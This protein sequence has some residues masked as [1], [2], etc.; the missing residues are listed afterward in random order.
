MASP[1]SLLPTAPPPSDDA[2]AGAAHSVREK[3]DEEGK[4]QQAHH[5]HHAALGGGEDE[6]DEEDGGVKLG[7]G[8]F[9]FYSVL[10]GRAAVYDF[11]TT[12][13]C[14]LAITTGLILTLFCLALF[15]KALPALPCSI[16]LGIATYAFTRFAI[17]PYAKPLQQDMLFF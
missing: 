13:T 16:F 1:D 3:E 12:L 14:F 8:D 4:H 7:L 17:V 10:M 5:G 9:V 6:E 15:R 2:K 11:T